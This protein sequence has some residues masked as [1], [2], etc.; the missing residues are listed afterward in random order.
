MKKICIILTLVLLLAGC[1]KQVPNSVAGV[2]V[3][4]N[5]RLEH[6]NIPANLVQQ[7]EDNLYRVVTGETLGASEGL[8]LSSGFNG[9][10]EYFAQIPAGNV[11][12]AQLRLQFLST[13][14]VG[15]IKLSAVD[16][17]GN[18]LK[19]VGWVVTGDMPLSANAT[20][21][22]TRTNAN[23][24][25]DWIE[26]DIL[27]NELFK[28]LPQAVGYRLSVETG[29]GQHVMITKLSFAEDKP[30]AITVTPRKT[31]YRTLLGEQIN[32]ETD[33]ENTSASA[34]T[35]LI[36]LSEPYGLGIIAQDRQQEIKL[37]PHE[38]KTLSWIVTTKRADAVNLNKPWEVSFAVDGQM[39]AA[40]IKFLI[41]DPRPGK[42]FY[43]MTE[44]LEPI[45]SAGY[46][47]A[48]GN[49]NGWI[50]PE[51]VSVQ[52]ISKAER[53]NE[54]AGQYGAKWTHYIAW[55]AI[56]AAGWAAKQSN[57]Q[58]WDKVID[59]VKKSVTHESGLGHE[60]AL[61]MHTDY[62]PYL[63]GN[64]L[65]YN[66]QTDGFWANHLR[67]GWAHSVIAEGDFSDY[68]SRN[69]ILYAYQ[70]ELDELSAA[71]G[72]G[73]IINARAGSFD[74]GN[75]SED[76]AKS[77]RVYRNIGLW[78]SSDADGNAG[79]LTSGDYGSEI[80]FA[81]PDDINS[82]A[83][84]I[85]DLGIVEFRPT[86]KKFLTYDS[87]SAETL[88]EKTAQGITA[89]TQDGKVRPGV[90]AIVG[91]THAMFMMGTSDWQ[92]LN[93]GQ[94]AVLSN[95]LNFIK[96]NYVD[97]ELLNFATGSELV[98]HYLDYYSP[99]PIGLYGECIHNNSLFSEYAIRILG[100][101][102]AR[103][104]SHP[105]EISV[106]YPLYL[107]NTA[108]YIEVFKNGSKIYA[109]WGLPT[110]YNDIRFV[111]NDQATYTMKIY[112]SS[113][114]SGILK[115]YHGIKYQFGQQK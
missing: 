12:R 87:D 42:I 113:F 3:L 36:T 71:S 89:F 43:V 106:K 105:H 93:G 86:P 70:K 78:G 100:Q 54:I 4:P 97:K 2:Q 35:A 19:T 53:L 57:T 52:M 107:R 81:K 66:P 6:F 46:Q 17:A 80:Y 73:Q 27:V 88:N 102:I 25:G 112:H 103:D 8:E 9:Q 37:L 50:D 34:V 63:P 18:I 98:K 76:E 33:V 91:F 7:G 58:A 114:I 90:H 20:W 10:M 16:A 110:P 44:D 40:S 75:G 55:P 104:S 82:K 65:S 47:K 28:E 72:K 62:D 14:G 11:V 108:Y 32:I 60:Y 95:H 39:A 68:A 21:Q 64:I 30:A 111:V 85:N 56:K 94:F 22:D 83:V 92:D 77:T 5:D 23:Y 41:S 101:D 59:N 45:D 29:K 61:H 49:S 96:Q 69:G 31:E 15:R 67:H 79:G 115:Q 109:T 48:W 13:Q 24:L 99:E 26:K 1:G 51:E 84:D 38:K 74:F